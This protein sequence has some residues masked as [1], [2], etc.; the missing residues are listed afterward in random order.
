MIKKTLKENY[1]TRD[2]TGGVYRLKCSG[3]GMFWLRSAKELDKALNRFQFFVKTNSHPEPV[4]KQAWQTYGAESFSFE[5]LETLEKKE[6]QT[7]LEY[8]ED[9]KVL[10]ELW[11]EKLAS[12]PNP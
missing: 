7:D 11:T 5:I 12:S 6:T 8:R 9:I 2:I 3:N 1:K 10:L 4:M